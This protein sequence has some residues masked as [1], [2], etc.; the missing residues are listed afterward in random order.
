[1]VTNSAAQAGL[2]LSTGPMTGSS[3]RI[4]PTLR[5][6]VASAAAMPSAGRLFAATAAIGGAG[7]RGDKCRK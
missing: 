5:K 2:A 6:R 1:M 7:A 4:T 3:P